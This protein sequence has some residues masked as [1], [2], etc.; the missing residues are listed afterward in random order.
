MLVALLVTTAVSS[1]AEQGNAPDS[2][3]SPAVQST[4]AVTPIPTPT[5]SAALAQPLGSPY[6]E[7]DLLFTIVASATAPNGA[8]VE[9][10]QAA[11]SPVT[12]DELEERVQ[13]E[14]VHQCSAFDPTFST[15]KS[16]F[17]GFEYVRGFV[18]MTDVSTGGVSWPTDPSNETL[19]FDF[20]Q[21]SAFIGDAGVYQSPC[22]GGT[23]TGGTAAGAA[24]FRAH[25][26]PTETGGWAA[27]SYGIGIIWE[28]EADARKL[29][30]V[31]TDCS[32]VVGPAGSSDTYVSDWSNYVQPYGGDGCY[33][34]ADEYWQL[35]PVSN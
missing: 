3:A 6:P 23:L 21:Y 17:D 19:V 27:T 16:V 34:G 18:T 11:Y 1:C 14:V 8:E 35:F 25:A 31:F 32:I 24:P 12:F 9:V 4:P 5:P 7:S 33:F 20:G 28:T 30:P 10:M 29:F 22:T 2:I 26:S 13:A 15:S